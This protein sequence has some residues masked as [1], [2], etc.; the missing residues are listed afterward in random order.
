[1]LAPVLLFTNPF[2]TSQLMQRLAAAPEYFPMGHGVQEAAPDKLNDPGSQIPHTEAP[3]PAYV[4]CKQLS[5]VAAPTPAYVP[6]GQFDAQDAAPSPLTF[7]ASQT[8][9]ISDFELLYFPPSQVTQ[10]SVPVPP[11]LPAVQLEHRAASSLLNVPLEQKRQLL[12][13]EEENVPPLQTA[14]S[15]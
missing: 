9:Q 15:V 12:D 4:P 10:T 2:A 6:A 1:M 13:E 3:M 7:P 14:H 8:M 5:H 11:L